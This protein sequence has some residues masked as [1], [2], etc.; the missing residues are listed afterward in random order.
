MIGWIAR[1]GDLAFVFAT[2]C[3][4]CSDP[5]GEDEHFHFDT[6]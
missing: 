3:I 1:H 6:G 4:A 2:Y 5:A